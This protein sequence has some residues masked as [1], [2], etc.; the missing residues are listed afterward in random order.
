MVKKYDSR[1]RLAYKNFSIPEAIHSLSNSDT[2]VAL[3]W[4]P[5]PTR[6]RL[7]ASFDEAY[8]IFDLTLAVSGALT[9]DSLGE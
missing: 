6:T 5:T 9:T 3:R 2:S 7:M 4:M 8:S 1:A